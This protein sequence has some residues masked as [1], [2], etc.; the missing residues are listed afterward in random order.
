MSQRVEEQL[1]RLAQNE[2]VTDS[3]RF[4]GR[5]PPEDLMWY[6]GAADV[7]VMATEYEGWSNVLLEAMACGLPVVTTRVGGN[8]E[9]VN[10]SSLGELVEFWNPSAFVDAVSRAL[11]QTWDRE[12]IVAYARSNEW[13]G[14]IDVLE[15]EFRAMV[16]PAQSVFCLSGRT[17]RQGRAGFAKAHKLIGC[18]HGHVTNY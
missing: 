18:S 6:Y 5:Q 13:S 9:V 4:C 3:V 15:R 12:Q 11:E 1:K 17:G 7:L 8:A 10:A 2:G 16:N 14:R